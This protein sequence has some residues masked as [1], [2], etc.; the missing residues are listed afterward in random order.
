LALRATAAAALLFTPV[1]SLLGSIALWLFTI[2]TFLV[3]AR[4]DYGQSGA[5]QLVAMMAACLSLVSLCG[6]TPAAMQL[7]LWFVALQSVLAYLAAGIAK[8]VSPVWRD[9]SAVGMIFNCGSYGTLGVARLLAA[10]P[11]LGVAASRAVIVF[12]CAFPLVLVLAAP[13]REAI[14]IAG[15]FFHL[16]NA[17]IMGLNDFLIVFVGTY[18]AVHW[19]SQRLEH[20]LAS[21]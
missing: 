12:E 5:D 9:G 16:L 10:R 13:W 19:A 4:Q 2:A 6:W 15:V 14:L 18:P 3:M 7:G 21:L 8:A 20:G 11:W 1:T 17:V